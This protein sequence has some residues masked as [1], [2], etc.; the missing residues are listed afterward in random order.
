MDPE[1]LIHGMLDRMQIMT[2]VINVCCNYDG[3][4]INYKEKF[5]PSKELLPVNVHF[6][7]NVK[8]VHKGKRCNSW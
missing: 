2:N 1:V 8:I 5:K 3:V 7:K 4:I 6:R